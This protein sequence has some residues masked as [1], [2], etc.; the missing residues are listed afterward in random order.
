MGIPVEAEVGTG[1]KEAAALGEW[2]DPG[3]LCRGGDGPGLRVFKNTQD[4]AL[5]LGQP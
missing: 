3:T 1:H 2:T 4:W 5:T